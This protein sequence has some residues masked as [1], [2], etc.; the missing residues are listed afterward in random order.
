MKRP[1]IRPIALCALLIASGCG[2]QAMSTL[3][4][5]KTAA[6]HVPVTVLLKVPRAATTLSARKPEYISPAT[7]AIQINNQAF[8]V[9]PSSPNCATQSDGLSCTF[10]V[11][12]P[13][14]GV[15]TFNIAT[16]DMP[17]T[18]A[19]AVQGNQLSTG[20]TT[21]TILAGQANV[22]KITLNGVPAQVNISIA[23]LTPP[24]GQQTTTPVNF[25]IRDADGYTIVGQYSAPITLYFE[26]GY[27]GDLGFVKNGSDSPGSTTISQSSDVIS[28]SY[29]GHRVTTTTIVGVLGFKTV[30]SATFT[31]VPSFGSETP[32]AASLVGSDI[33]T[34][35]GGQHV[36]F[37]EPAKGDLA[38][39]SSGSPTITEVAFPSGGKPT[40][41][42]ASIYP[43]DEVYAAESGSADYADV[44]YYNL[45][46]YEQ[47]LSSA[48]V[49]A[50]QVAAPYSSPASY[51]ITESAVG[52]IAIGTSSGVTE[53]A[54][55]VA[56]STPSGIVYNSGGYYFADPGANAIGSI[57]T[58]GGAIKMYPVPSPGAQPTRMSIDDV[59]DV[60]FTEPGV[61]RV[62]HFVYP[63]NITE[64]PCSGVPVQVIAGQFASAALMSNGDIDAYNSATG[65]YVVAHAPASSAG[66]IVAIGIRYEGDAVVLHSNGTTGSIQD[67][68]Y[69]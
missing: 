10:N 37:T 29:P 36:W 27:W 59:W 49:G 62:A 20:S 52:K 3:P 50:Y 33:V 31:P 4:A 32:I 23:N 68:Y 60:W 18:S 7:Q 53:Y 19:G 11:D 64:L 1:G 48:S 34:T 41:L 44:Q 8:N 6:T 35:D 17:L 43:Y 28:L 38:V 26:G 42:T 66:P 39:M 13:N 55:G 63:Q 51:A 40:H 21:V 54:T 2:Q 58:G 67:F 24:I 65:Q 61:S 12:A 14:L 30:Y 69:F 45:M 57:A 9:T 16:Y 46:P 47:A 25:D 56:N 15:A 22:V 5:K